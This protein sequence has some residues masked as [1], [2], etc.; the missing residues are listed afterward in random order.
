M[1]MIHRLANKLLD[2]SSSDPVFLFALS[3]TTKESA[4]SYA[5][6]GAIGVGFLST[7][8]IS[9]QRS[10]KLRQV[11]KEY[12]QELSHLKNQECIPSLLL[13]CE[14]RALY[15]SS[16]RCIYLDYNGTTPIREEV[17]SA[18]IPYL[19]THFGNPSSAHYYGRQPKVAI[20]RARAEIA[21]LLLTQEQV[22][23]KKLVEETSN[24]IIFTGCG[25][26]ADNMAIHLA[27]YAWFAGRKT[28]K[29]AG[30]PHVVTC[31]VEHPA[32][33]ECLKFFE[34]R[35]D[36]ETTYVKVDE[37]G[38]VS[39]SDVIDVIR[40]NTCFVTLMLANNESGAIMPVLEVASFCR[41]KGVL[42]H[43]DAAQAVG[44]LAM[45]LERL[46]GPDMIT[47]VGHKFGAPKGVAALYV[48]PGCLGKNGRKEPDLYGVSGGLLLGGGQETGRRAGTE[49]VP[50]IVG[51]GRAASL[52]SGPN[53]VENAAHMEQMRTKL[54]D[55]LTR[56]LGKE[57]IRANGPRERERRLPNTLSVGIKNV[58][59]GELLKRV[60]EQVAA[61]AGSA[62]HASGGKISAVLLAM[63]VPIEFANGTLRLSV[64]VG[65]SEA[66]L[67]RATE[68]IA[69]EAR[70][71][72][73][74]KSRDA[75]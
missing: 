1:K 23:D 30:I 25:T 57:N 51:M 21:S 24:A 60:G 26:E 52:V 47:L 10:R 53:L 66:D 38:L 55:N 27:V 58:H 43:T 33:A 39:A 7:A 61:S 68:I 70:R 54:I 65:T 4:R 40:P 35:G 34:Q 71:Q 37:E 3:P 18:M 11:A 16:T 6:V 62:C 48:R 41:K 63:N 5:V 72:W 14:D 56:E 15:N 45:D 46:G 74:T 28:N 17:V 32:V 59:S 75:Q 9:L 29:E 67:D 36:I 49:N 69:R 44:K 73:E 19:T 2:S 8:W 42:F 64:G 50:Y 20:Q 12:T 13:T 22:Q 31:N